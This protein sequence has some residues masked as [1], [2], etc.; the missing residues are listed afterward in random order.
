MKKWYSLLEVISFPL[1]MLFFGTL[2]LGL[3]DF[4]LNS[5]IT[6]FIP[7]TNDYLI[8]LCTGLKYLGSFLISCFPML[9]VI[10]LLSKRYEDS[11][12]AF[13]GIISYIVFH[14]VTMFVCKTDLPSYYY[15]NVMGITTT[16][17][18]NGLGLFGTYSPLVTGLVGSTVVASLT[19]WCY[20]RSRKRFDYGVLSFIDNDSWALISSVVW[21]VIL[22][23]AFSFGWPYVIELLTGIFEFIGSD[24]YN[25]ANLMVYGML[26]RILSVLHLQDLIHV[27]FWFGELGGSWMDNFGLLYTGDVSVWTAL[28]SQNLD[29]L[30]FG[31]FITPYYVL[32]IFAVPGMLLAFLSLHT[33]KMERKRYVLFFVL[34][35]L[36]SANT[37][38]VLPLELFLIVAAPFLF[39][40]HMVA[41]G[42][43]YA[44]FASM[45]VMLGYTFTGSLNQAM[46]GTVISIIPYVGD[47]TYEQTLIYILAIGGIYALMYFLVTRLYYK[48]LSGDFLEVGANARRKER[49]IQAVGGIENVRIINSSLN[50]VT[51]HLYDPTKMDNEELLE[52]GAY[53]I[54]ETRAGTLIEFGPKSTILKDA[55]RK[56]MKKYQ[57]EQKAKPVISDT[58]FDVEER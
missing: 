10:K 34:A 58:M 7:I 55:V 37:G 15:S 25:P 46:P 12:P 52:I 44:I 17:H 51:V 20:L 40:F 11:V 18:I 19:R 31:R 24:I 14:V 36:V 26:E 35:I 29:T 50:K 21:S 22:G 32:N 3:G 57:E 13:V 6:P 56:E 33:D 53:R 47:V 1:K 38:I 23:I 5:N 42:A 49:F 4:F 8:L 41:S 30:G 2:I 39:F 45:S 48:V 43:L 27:P 16:I 54:A 28:I 9:I